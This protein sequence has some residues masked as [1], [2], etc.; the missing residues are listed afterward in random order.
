MYFCFFDKKQLKK[1]FL[2]KLKK[3]LTTVKMFGKINF[4]DARE[5]NR[6]ADSRHR[7]LEIG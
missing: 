2:K 6:Q 1:L 3:V 4:A 5:S 7:T